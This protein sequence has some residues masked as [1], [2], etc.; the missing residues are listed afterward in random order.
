[1]VCTIYWD[2]REITR[3]RTQSQTMELMNPMDGSSSSSSP[4]VS[5]N[6][7]IILCANQAPVHVQL[8][9]LKFGT[10]LVPGFLQT[11]AWVFNWK[12]KYAD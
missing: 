10:Y 1:M 12:N 3:V 6:R 8:L 5:C 11:V 4:P 2:S 9:Y 7:S